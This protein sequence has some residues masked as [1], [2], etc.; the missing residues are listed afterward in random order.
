VVEA[1]E[2]AG[3]TGAVLIRKLLVE[4]VKVKEHD[5]AAVN[6]LA[7][8]QLFNQ[9]PAKFFLRGVEG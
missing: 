5:L 6:D 9:N 4:V 8:L 7:L 3:D 1:V 2:S